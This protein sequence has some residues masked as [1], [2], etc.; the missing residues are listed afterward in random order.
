MSTF[1]PGSAL[2]QVGVTPPTAPGDALKNLRTPVT[3]DPAATE[4]SRRLAASHRRKRAEME[5]AELQTKALIAANEE[6]AN[7]VASKRHKAATPHRA[8][9]ALGR[10]ATVHNAQSEAKPED[11][12][13][14]SP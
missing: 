1:S 4:L 3:P 2:A 8:A 9:G 12:G 13:P 7:A 11:A 10:P 6:P 14:A 5:A